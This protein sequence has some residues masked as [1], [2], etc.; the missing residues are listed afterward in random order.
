MTNIILPSCKHQEHT[1]NNKII[2]IRLNCCKKEWILQA[3]KKVFLSR[4]KKNRN[5]YHRT[6]ILFNYS[7]I[8][9]GCEEV[10]TD[11][12]QLVPTLLKLNEFSIK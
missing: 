9:N 10:L 12:K 11:I 8:W 3:C 6:V 4:P 5:L 1:I 7:R 2:I